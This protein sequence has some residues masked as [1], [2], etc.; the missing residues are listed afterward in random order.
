MLHQTTVELATL[1]LLIK[2]QADNTFSNF[3]LAG[4]TSLALQIGHRKSI[5]LYLFSHYNFDNNSLLEYLEEKYNFELNYIA[6][7]TL[8]GVISGIKVDFLSHKYNLVKD[9]IKVNNLRLL[10]IEDI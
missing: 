8:K 2:L 5:D 9:L 6:K 10:S 4:G 3:Y 1:E 7:N